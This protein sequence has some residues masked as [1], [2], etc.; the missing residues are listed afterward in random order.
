MADK[1][2]LAGEPITVEEMARNP[3]PFFE[4][5]QVH[6]PVCWMP[7][8][9]MWMLTRHADIITLLRDAK[10]FTMEP[11][12]NYPNPMQELFGPM[13]LSI[14]G[15][16][17]RRIRKVFIEPFRPRHV[18]EWYTDMIQQISQTL[19]DEFAAQKT[20]DLDKAFSDRLAI[21]VIVA[22]LGYEVNDMRQFR[23]WYDE[24]GASIGNVQ[25]D[26]NVQTRGQRAFNHFRA[27]T[28]AQVEALKIAPNQS[29]LS[30]MIHHM[31][32]Q[33]TTEELVSNIALTFFGG[34]ETTS[35][36]FSNAIWA[37]LT[38]P[39]QLQEVQDNPR[40]LPQAIEEALRWEAPVQG[41]MRFPTQDVEIHGVSIKKG[42]KIYGMLGAA[43]RDTAVFKNPSIYDIHRSNANKHLSFAYGPHICFGA[44]LAR[45]EA[46][47]GIGHL[48]QRLPKLQIDPKRAT[49]PYG[50]EFRAPP[51]LFAN[52]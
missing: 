51:T 6:R 8:F 26:P 49:Q 45:L 35:A 33:L 12:P 4:Q 11:Q 38:H 47:I 29:I 25:N 14:D 20:A 22:A 21:F 50:H 36:L 32:N 1:P 39:E 23:D 28:L 16:D 42:E 27:I 18:R 30:Q 3:Y 15:P 10:R 31:G 48:L 52:W 7:A 5:M 24:F 17:H 2:T 19:V 44:P 40:H 41:A 46:K 34:V 9:N 43:N 37:L 13:M